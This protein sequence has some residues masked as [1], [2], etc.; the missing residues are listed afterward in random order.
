MGKLIDIIKDLF[1]DAMAASIEMFKVMV[2]VIILVKILQELDLIKYLAWPL[3]PLMAL[4]GLPAEMG[5][6]WATA[7]INTTYA[8][9]IVFLSLVQE[10][11]L[12]TAQ[13]TIVAVLILTCHALPM[14]SSIARKSG[15]RFF[16][17]CFSRIVGALILAWLLN[18][19]YTSTGSLQEP[20]TILFQVD[21]QTIADPSL[22]NWAWDQG[23]NLL[24]IFG[25]ILGLL[26]VMRILYAIKVIDMMNKILRPILKIIGI[27]PKASAITVIG[28]T[29]GLSYGGGLIINEAQ[30]GNI[31]KED[32]FYS[33]TLMGLCHSLIEDTL[34]ML[35]IGGNFNG[36]FWSRLIFALVA[37]AGIVQIV[38]RL[39]KRFQDTYLWVDK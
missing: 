15:A 13:A 30:A 12:T 17:Q 18:L 9:L 39:P 24:S 1:R 2:P 38:R 22:L 21:Q 23:K 7:M 10:N 8:G 33:L 11:P 27:G 3:K 35:L 34:L 26:I 29:M 16:F 28:L 6:A 32:I 36:I 5:L 25:V 31:G 4:V 20:A 19:F 14:E 37:M